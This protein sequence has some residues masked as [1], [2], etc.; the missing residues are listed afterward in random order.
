MNAVNLTEVEIPDSVED[1][2][3]SAFDGCKNISEINLSNSLISMGDHVFKGCTALKEITIP[4]KVTKMGSTSFPVFEKTGIEKVVFEEGITSVPAYACMNAVNLTEV[5]IPDSVTSIGDY[6]FKSC[7]LLKEITIPKKVTTIGSKNYSAFEKTGIEKVVFGEGLLYVPQNSFSNLTTLKYVEIPESTFSIEDGAFNNCKNLISVQGIENVVNIGVSAFNNCTSLQTV[8]LSNTYVIGNSAFVNCNGLENVKLDK[9]KYIRSNA[10]EN[11]T[12]LDCVE[13]GNIS[14][15][16]DNVFLNCSALNSVKIGSNLKTIEDGVFKGTGLKEIE[17]PFGVENINANAFDDIP[18]TL[19]IK[20]PYSIKKIDANAFGTTNVVINCGKGSFTSDY[21]K[22]NGIN[23]NYDTIVHIEDLNIPRYLK[24][25]KGVTKDISLNILNTMDSSQIEVIAEDVD[26]VNVSPYDSSKSKISINTLK[27]G[28]TNVK[29]KIGEEEHL[30]KIDVVSNIDSII[31]AEDKLI[32]NSLDAYLLEYETYP[33]ATD[34]ELIWETMDS[35]VATIDN[36][37]MITPLKEGETKVIAKT[38]EGK[39]LGK[40]DIY[41]VINPVIKDFDFSVEE[42]T[43]KVNKYI[44]ISNCISNPNNFDNISWSIEDNEIAEIDG[45]NIRGLNVGS[46][47][48]TGKLGN[49]EKKIKINVE[50]E[51]FYIRF[52]KEYVVLKVGG[53]VLNKCRTNIKDEIL[54]W[55]YDNSMISIDEDGEILAIHRGITEVVVTDKTKGVSNSFVV[56]VKDDNKVVETEESKEIIMVKQTEQATTKNVQET[57]GEHNSRK[58]VK[59]KKIKKVKKC[60]KFAFV[61]NFKYK[62]VEVKISKNK[63]FKKAK[64]FYTTKK[65]LK[66]SKKYRKYYYRI[67]AVYIKNGRILKTKWTKTKKIK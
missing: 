66:V 48:L 29:V 8:A 30:I 34:D 31:F 41:V 52:D 53:S 63:K 14:V 36:Q 15:L 12:S 50:K 5:E 13:I 57:I 42:I 28:S 40:I 24:L 4:Q 25:Y 67:R 58:I 59:V 7:G 2:G 54:K 11:C 1:I 18:N 27:C 33:Q 49:V 47:V 37:G 26:I 32:L 62:K 17:I 44:N 23:Y 6:A 56:V 3:T 22:K 43:L 39:V 60:L 9:A 55:K 20:L 65:I 35:S 10:F 19:E 61:A 46:T 45:T 38:I 16:E 21:C 51:E 64:M